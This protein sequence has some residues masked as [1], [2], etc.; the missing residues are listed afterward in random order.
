MVNQNNEIIVPNPQRCLILNDLVAARLQ[1][2]GLQESAHYMCP[3]YL[4]PD[5]EYQ[6][7][8]FDHQLQ[9]EIPFDI[10]IRVWCKAIC[11]WMYMVIDHFDSEREL[12]MI[13]MSYFDRYLATTGT[14]NKRIIQLVAVSAIN[15]TNKLYEPQKTNTIDILLDCCGGYFVEE[16]VI[17]MECNIL[18]ALGWYL[19]PPTP[20][21]FLREM[22]YILPIEHLCDTY[23]IATFLTELSVSSYWYVTKKPSCIALACLI[24]ALELQVMS[25]VPNN[26]SLLLLQELKLFGLDL[27]KN[28]DDVIE[29]CTSLRDMYIKDRGY[30]LVD[31]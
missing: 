1:A 4:S 6:E 5:D 23:E 18:W 28:E 24:S 2:M 7:A 19:H 26:I 10:S 21:A 20:I 25:N 9:P 30:A 27:I 22:V 15:L 17:N 14:I 16:H 31:D 12:V 29:C 11:E 3:D 13:G 8:V